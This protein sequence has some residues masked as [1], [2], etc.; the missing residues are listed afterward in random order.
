MPSR[1]ICFVANDRILSSL[2][3]RDAA[4]HPRKRA[5]RAYAHTCR[6]CERVRLTACPSTS[7]EPSPHLGHRGSHGGDAGG[8]GGGTRPSRERFCFLRANTRT[9]W[10]TG[11]FRRPRQLAFPA[12]D[13]ATTLGSVPAAPVSPPHGPPARHFQELLLHRRPLVPL[14]RTALQ[15]QVR[16][17][18]VRGV[19]PGPTDAGSRHQRLHHQRRV[20]PHG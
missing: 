5:C 11:H 2:R 14:R 4:Q 9:G 16:V 6:A 18:V 8:G 17:L 20:G 12:G 7:L 13:E 1:S 19:V 10:V 3:L 15:A